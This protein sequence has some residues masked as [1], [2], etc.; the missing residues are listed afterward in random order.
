MNKFQISDGEV[1]VWLEQETVH[2]KAV[3]PYGDPVEL[4][5]DEAIELAEA[6]LKIAQEIKE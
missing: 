5:K 3:T 4:W 6:I 1:R 2:M